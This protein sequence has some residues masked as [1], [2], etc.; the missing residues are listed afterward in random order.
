M[1]CRCIA[2]RLAVLLSIPV[3][4]S[5]LASARAA[6]RA[7]EDIAVTGDYTVVTRKVEIADLN[8][9]S[10]DDQRRLRQRLSVAA[11]RVCAEAGGTT[12]VRDDSLSSCYETSMR[13]AWA[14]V[15]DRI[16]IASANAHSMAN[17]QRQMPVRQDVASS[18]SR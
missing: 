5:G 7:D 17:A 11:R 8:L 18:L 13:D 14:S 2:T 10:P 12:V 16:S 15:Q 3:L 9:A 4:V 6:D 1:F